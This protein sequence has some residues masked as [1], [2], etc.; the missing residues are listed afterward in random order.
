VK[1]AVRINGNGGG[2]SWRHDR[3]RSRP[4]ALE[5]GVP[6]ET[7]VGHSTDRI[8]VGDM[9]TGGPKLTLA[10]NSAGGGSSAQRLLAIVLVAGLLAMWVLLAIGWADLDTGMEKR[11]LSSEEKRLASDL[12]FGKM[13]AI[14]Q[15]EI[16][17]LG[18]AW[19]LLFLAESRVSFRTFSSYCLLVATT[20]CFLTSLVAY[21]FGYDFVVRRIF[22][23]ETLDIH[24]P[25]VEFWWHWQRLPFVVGCLALAITILVC[26]RPEK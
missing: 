16:A 13:T 4:A 7:L 8:V 20:L 22:D 17:V 2:L 14:A 26:R 18:G 23:H 5:V 6:K 24:A 10:S 15:V 19:A 21:D 12:F 11:R 3:N 25:V 9:P 1:I